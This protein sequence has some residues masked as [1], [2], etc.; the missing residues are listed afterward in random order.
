MGM[1][2]PIVLEI[3]H[4]TYAINEFGMKYATEDQVIW[5]NGEDNGYVEQYRDV[6]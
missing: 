2:K 5:Y 6:S 4:R 1:T 3:A